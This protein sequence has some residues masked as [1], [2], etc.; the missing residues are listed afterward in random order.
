ML[1]ILLANPEA[2][3][4]AR[5]CFRIPDTGGVAFAYELINPPATGLKAVPG[6]THIYVLMFNIPGYASK[7]FY[8]GQ[9]RGLTQR[10]G[11]HQMITWH[12]ARFGSP[13]KIYIAGLVRTETADL[14]EQNLIA[15]LRRAGYRLT[16][17]MVVRAGKIVRQTTA[18][19]TEP[20][21]TT[22]HHLGTPS[23]RESVLLAWQAQFLPA[24]GQRPTVSGSDLHP[25]EVLSY[26][27]ALEYPTPA[28]RHVSLRIAEAFDPGF[29]C[30]VIDIVP[31]FKGKQSAKNLHHTLMRMRDVWVFSKGLQPGKVKSYRLTKKHT[32]AVLALRSPP[33]VGGS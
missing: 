6:W 19:L 10:F 20:R 29:Q 17:S 14:A 22:L 4:P 33:S 25:D 13:P 26:V 32:A 16:N 1:R 15:R 11:N 9:A 21:E 27:E 5:L 18:F 7:P 24:D 23:P 28:A 31:E 8:V 2:L 12:A 3:S 30:S